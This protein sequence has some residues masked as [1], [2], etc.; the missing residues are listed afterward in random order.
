LANADAAAA[1]TL[2]LFNCLHIDMTTRKG[3]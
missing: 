2:L 1:A 3:S